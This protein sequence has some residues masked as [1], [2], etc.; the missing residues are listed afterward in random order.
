[1]IGSRPTD[2][3]IKVDVSDIRYVPSRSFFIGSS[4][5][6][7]CETSGVFNGLY[8]EMYGID[9][10]DAKRMKSWMV[11]GEVET[12]LMCLGSDF[13]DAVRSGGDGR[14]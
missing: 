7:I 10:S 6:G 5:T 8:I 14:M 1:M 9:N 13:L 12:R 3:N 11:V 4:R 2:R